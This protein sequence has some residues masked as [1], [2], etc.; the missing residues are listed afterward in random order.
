MQFCHGLF[1]TAIISL[2][3]RVDLM[4][5]V[6]YT[7]VQMDEDERRELRQCRLNK[8]L[9]RSN[10]INYVIGYLASCVKRR[11]DRGQNYIARAL[12][13]LF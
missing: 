6:R 10:K 4:Q 8:D 7:E 3:F 11:D 2:P 12:L 1:N 5:T 13:A 9:A